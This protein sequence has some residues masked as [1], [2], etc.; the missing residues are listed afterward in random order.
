MILLVNIF[1]L[2]GSTNVPSTNRCLNM[3]VSALF[4][5]GLGEGATLYRTVPFMGT[6]CSVPTMRDQ[7]YMLRV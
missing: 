5:A 6:H 7:F 2:Q 3:R 4:G 1:N